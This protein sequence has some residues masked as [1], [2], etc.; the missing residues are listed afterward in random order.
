MATI[1]AMEFGSTT[2]AVARASLR[3]GGVFVS[4]ME[5]LD[6]TAFPGTEAFSTGL[7]QARK[8]LKLPRRLHA[9]VWGLPDGVD[10]KDPAVAPVLAPI[11]NA[12]FRVERVVTPC[13][14][15]A[16]LA[17]LR[18]PRL[19]AATCWLAINRDGVAIVAIRPGKQL[20]ANSFVWNSSF[21]ATGSQA[22]LLQR[23]S[24]VSVLAPEVRRA[25]AAAR[26]EGTPIEGIVTC[27]NLPDLRSLTM[28]LIEEL[29]LEVETLDSLEG[30]SV[31]PGIAGQLGDRA[32]AIR[33]ACAAASARGT[34]PWLAKRPVP[35]GSVAAAA[36]A[37]V[38]I[39]AA[40]WF[41][42]ARLATTKITEAHRTDGRATPGTSHPQP[43]TSHT[44]VTPKN[45]KPVA[46]PPEP[47]TGNRQPIP[48][49]PVIKNPAANN[50]PAI[51][52]PVTDNAKPAAAQ[53]SAS[54]PRV[55]RVAPPPTPSGNSAGAR[56]D[57]RGAAPT[58]HTAPLPPLLKDPL[59][60]VTGI[61][62]GERRRFAT[63][64]EGHII[65]VGDTIGRR[66]VVAIDQRSV[67]L[68]EPSGVQIRVGLGGKLE[69]VSRTP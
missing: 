69:G 56:A 29:D 63:I 17:R 18:T 11:V 53:P 42:Y 35:I 6:P 33:I 47:A 49:I 7:R 16:A 30:L 20:Y 13:N 59:P 68:R 40:G 9:V 37:V 52:N 36:A 38:A 43:A 14:A 19:N 64:D 28:P 32:A 48:S 62:V 44:P 3:R 66:T 1:T 57:R 22:R 67:V 15:L 34:R 2:C 27:G 65:T 12:G 8:A 58:A 23:Y 24:L 25:M 26:S 31:K 21:G 5:V 4:A 54:L 61:L 50:N 51:K 45:P 39:A 60:R 41:G 46:N 55:S 10:R